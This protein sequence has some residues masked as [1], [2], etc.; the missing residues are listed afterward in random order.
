[1]LFSVHGF[2][3]AIGS[4]DRGANRGG[5]LSLVRY[6]IPA[7]KVFAAPASQLRPIARLRIR[8]AGIAK[9]RAAGR[10]KDQQPACN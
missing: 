4:G 8:K 10:T 9:S 7:G 2:S 5:M 1:M 6:R 3:Q